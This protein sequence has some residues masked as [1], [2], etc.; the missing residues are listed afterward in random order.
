[1]AGAGADDDE[2]A[3]G[4]ATSGAQGSDDEAVDCAASGAGG[5]D[6]KVAE[7][8]AVS[9]ADGSDDEAAEGC[10]ASG[11]EGGG[12]DVA[13]EGCSPFCTAVSSLSPF[14]LLV[15]LALA[16]STSRSP[17]RGVPVLECMTHHAIF[18]GLGPCTTVCIRHVSI[19]PSYK[20]LPKLSV[21]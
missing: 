3:G 10:A 9:G 11:V 14:H 5:S 16:L 1:L 13:S 7:G 12:W 19:E 2:A 15:S 17:C 20:F 18:E 21:G 8:C 6:N 4:C